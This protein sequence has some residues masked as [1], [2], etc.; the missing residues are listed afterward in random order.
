M[1]SERN[2]IEPKNIKKYLESISFPRLSG[3]QYEQEAADLIIKEIKE[4]NLNPHVQEFSFSSFYSRIYK[5]IA[6]SLIL[7]LVFIIFLNPNRLFTILNVIIIITIFIPLIFYTRNPEKIRFGTNY[8][9]QNVY[10]Q[11]KSD[12]RE[13]GGENQLNYGSPSPQN[14]QLLFVSHID[15]KYQTL[16][17]N[18]RVICL[19]SW[20]YSIII[21]AGL[22]II[23]Y[24]LIDI[25]IVNLLIMVGLGI[26]FF[27]TI[28]IIINT[29]GNKSNGA[30]DNGSGVALMLELLKY[31]SNP[32]KRPHN[33]DLWFLFTGAEETG[34]MGIRYLAPIFE[35]YPKQ[36]VI[37]FNIDSI[38]KHLDI[39]GST[40]LEKYNGDF[41][42][43]FFDAF[44]DL[45]SKIHI[46]R[47][48]SAI[49]R[50]DGYYLKKQGYFGV[51][52]GDKK[53]Y[54]YIH[55]V[56]DIIDKVD[57]VLLSKICKRFIKFL[58]VV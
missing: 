31:Y 44:R 16:P 11:L 53:S 35:K 48:I 17:I 28:M 26:N 34:T 38:A 3:T 39:F 15:S 6:F 5:K 24:L 50:S 7:W 18:L 23:K 54:K 47:Y 14:L 12:E 37:F 10:L 30:I 52:F 4:L 45:A 55:S 19:K 21:I 2:V 22:L 20:I 40:E 9:S 1:E 33:K 41:F 8:E 46:K 58:E 27:S 42:D 25:F 49:T 32:Q 51:D 36:K 57:H 13:R 56:N 29:S 43:L